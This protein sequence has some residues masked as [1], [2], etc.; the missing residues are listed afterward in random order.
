VIDVILTHWLQL[1][2]ALLLAF[3]LFVAAYM[4]PKRSVR[5][6]SGGAHPY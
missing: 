5:L 6:V 2:V 3:A 4:L 1:S